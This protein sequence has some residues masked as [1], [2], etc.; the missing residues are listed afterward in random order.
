MFIHSS[1][2]IP[3]ESR[4]AARIKKSSR[5][6]RARE[7]LCAARTADIIVERRGIWVSFE[8]LSSHRPTFFPF[9][10]LPFLPRLALPLRDHSHSRLS[11]VIGTRFFASKKNRTPGNQTLLTVPF[12]FFILSF[13]PPSHCVPFDRGN[14]ESAQ[15]EFLSRAAFPF[16]VE[17]HAIFLSSY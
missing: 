4:A 6:I 14:K 10:L 11:I 13:V 16:V 9:S 8:K 1:Q 12:R 3:P 5:I 7:R 15:Y 2:W 17:I